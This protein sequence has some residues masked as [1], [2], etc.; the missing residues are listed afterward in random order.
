MANPWPDAPFVG[1]RS[2]GQKLGRTTSKSYHS[3]S[4]LRPRASWLQISSPSPFPASS[5][6][7][8]YNTRTLTPAPG[9]EAFHTVQVRQIPRSMLNYQGEGRWNNGLQSSRSMQRHDACV[10]YEVPFPWFYS[11]H[12]NCGDES[13]TYDQLL[14]SSTC[15]PQLSTGHERPLTIL[16]LTIRQC[17]WCSF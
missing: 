5:D 12:R 17:K 3:R 10:Q 6:I 2:Y 8:S 13:L 7:R 4:S 11:L 16:F 9:M 14:D 1:R 15:C